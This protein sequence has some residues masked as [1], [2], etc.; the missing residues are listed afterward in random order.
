MTD[1]TIEERDGTY[2][3]RYERDLSHPIERVWQAITDPDEIAS[4]MGSRPEIDL[5][6]G[7]CYVTHHGNGVTVVDRVERVEPPHLFQHTFWLEVNPSA[8]VT[9][10]LTATATG[11]HLTLTHRMSQADVEAAA[12]SVAKGGSLA[13]ILSRNAAGWHQLLDKLDARLDGRE[14]SWSDKE[15]QKLLIRYAAMLD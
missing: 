6:P 5:H 8:R 1:G 10:E 15:H 12:N 3:F 11:C 9:W 14:R 13:L 4:W 2:L 7:G